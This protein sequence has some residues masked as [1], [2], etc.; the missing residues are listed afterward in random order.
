VPP[1]KVLVVDD[2]PDIISILTIIL[3][4]ADYQVCEAYSPREAHERL[5]LDDPDLILLDVMMPNEAEGL[6]FLHQLR[7]EY[8]AAVAKRPVIILSGVYDVPHVRVAARLPE[9]SELAAGELRV[10][11]F[12]RKPPDPSVLLDLVAQVLDVRE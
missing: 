8:P 12:L 5:R 6:I 7:E 3:E 9:Q 2:D 11:G 1:A 4:S 10:Q